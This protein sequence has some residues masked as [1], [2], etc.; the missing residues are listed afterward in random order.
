MRLYTERV[1]VCLLMLLA[2]AAMAMERVPTLW[3]N[4]EKIIM[5]CPDLEHAREALRNLMRNA[6]ASHPGCQYGSAPCY[7]ESAIHAEA[8]DLVRHLD[9]MY[10]LQCAEV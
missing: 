4:D 9:R 8:L 2:S 10:A 1:V 3:W 6:E 5:A 7:A